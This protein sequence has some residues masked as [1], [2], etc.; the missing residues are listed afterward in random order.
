M[1]LEDEWV[2]LHWGEHAVLG[3]CC[4]KYLEYELLSSD[5]NLLMTAR[6]VSKCSKHSYIQQQSLLLL[7]VTAQS[8]KPRPAKCKEITGLLV[9]K[10][11]IKLD[12]LLVRTSW[13][14]QQIIWM[15]LNCIN[16]A[17]ML[18]KCSQ[19]FTSGHV[20]QLKNINK[21]DRISFKRISWLLLNSMKIWTTYLI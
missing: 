4:L 12:P 11:S 2:I 14:Q 13:S 16:R 21:H 6:P 1:C 17:I 9:K 8:T 20:P 18:T 15:E 10:I 19:L 7:A 3:S 5:Q